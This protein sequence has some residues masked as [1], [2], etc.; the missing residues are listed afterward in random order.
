MRHG[1]SISLSILLLLL[2]LAAFADP[3][4]GSYTSTSR[5]GMNPGVQ[6]GRASTSR[7]FPN[8]GNPKVFNGQSWSGS[9][10]AAQ[11]E[12]KCGV[13]TMLTPPD[14]TNFNRITGTGWITY[15]QTFQGGVFA[16]YADPAVGWGSGTGTLGTTSIISQVQFF[17][18]TPYSSSFTGVTSGTFDIGCTMDFA[19]ANGFGAG[20]TPYLA[21]PATYPVFL[22]DDCSP[23]DGSHQFGTWGDVN[24]IIV[25]INAD[26][27]T[28]THRSTWGTVKAMYR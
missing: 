2:S 22:A 25:K 28:P 10:L 24:D 21:K 14:S 23:A 5:P 1:F 27:A 7:Q 11:W 6:V 13:E 26:C 20:E 18:F 17:N 8:S 19:M 9:T 15:R 16:L 3:V 12:I 4:P